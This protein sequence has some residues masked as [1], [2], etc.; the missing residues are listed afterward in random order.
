MLEKV[1]NWYKSLP[2]RKPWVDL[3]TAVLTIPVLL[4][5]IISNV[6]NLKKNGNTIDTGLSPTVIKE[7]VITKV[8]TPTPPPAV[9]PS[10]SAPSCNSEPQEYNIVF[11]GEGDK[12]AADPLF[13]A[14]EKI[15]GDYCTSL[16]AYRI[17]NSSWSTYNDDPIGLYNMAAGPVKL[18]IRVKSTVSGK[19]RT[20][21]RNFEYGNPPTLAPSPS[22]GP[23][24][25][26]QV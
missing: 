11:P 20:Y 16:W 23:T 19:E 4:T 21:V 18:E 14:M 8:I 22:T 24:I 25:T 1:R 26:P 13:I 6:G 10:T 17:N 3:V 12:V 5:V 15:G 7:T 9:S 2:N